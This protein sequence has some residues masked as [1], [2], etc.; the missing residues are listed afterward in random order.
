MSVPA[1]KR[2]VVP[3]VIVL[4]VL[5]GC[6]VKPASDDN[7]VYKGKVVSVIDGD[8]VRVSVNGREH[9]VRM[10]GVDAPE[11]TK[12]KEPYGRESAAFT[13]Q[14]LLGKPVYLERDV[15][16][17]DRYGRMLAYI[18]T[19]DSTKCEPGSARHKM[20]NALLVAEGYAVVM[21]VPPNIK[22]ADLFAELQA[23]A[24][25]NN[26]GL[27]ALDVDPE[28][29]YVANRS[30]KK[31]HRPSCPH[32]GKVSSQNRVTFSS[33]DEAFDNGFEP[34]RQCNP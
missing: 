11:Y 34:C 2:F 18:W 4:L 22:Y 7:T 3:L 17:T 32:A 12:E 19:E 9:L 6:L 14:R 28:P 15:A 5:A 30:S 26:K 8:T 23:E 24:R 27:W 25:R 13:E 1:I 20:F 21:T 33:R 10:I 29:Y 16:E 31:F